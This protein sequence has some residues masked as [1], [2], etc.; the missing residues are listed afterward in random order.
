MDLEKIAGSL[1]EDTRARLDA[2]SKSDEVKA[3]GGLI[4]DAE[5][6]SAARSGDQAAMGSI[7]KRV[8]STGE[9]KRLAQMIKDAMK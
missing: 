1:D 9:G 4:S 7:L 3:L 5:L 2:L 8:L 6:L